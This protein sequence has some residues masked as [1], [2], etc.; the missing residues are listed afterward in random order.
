MEESS[1]SALHCLSGGVRKNKKFRSPTS[2]SV[3]WEAPRMAL[4]TG[5]WPVYEALQEGRCHGR[6]CWY[7]V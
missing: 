7:C 6:L 2:P 1:L 3:L 5:G 4:V